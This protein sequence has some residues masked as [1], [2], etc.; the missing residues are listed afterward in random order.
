MGGAYTST[1]RA[2][3][4]ASVGVWITLA[5]VGAACAQGLQ[6]LPPV[7]GSPL[8]APT[9]SPIATGATP[10]MVESP[11]TALPVWEAPGDVSSVTGPAVGSIEAT[12][13]YAEPFGGDA[14]FSS[15]VPF[16]DDVL[17]HDL[18][19]GAGDSRGIERI[20]DFK[21]GF[22]Q[23]VGFTGT[24]IP[25]FDDTDVGFSDL[26]ALASF[27]VPLPTTE[28]PMLITPK[29]MVRYLD[30]PTS[31][32]LPARLYDTSIEFRWLPKLTDRLR[33]A[34]AI[35]P[36]LHTD[37]EKSDAD[38]FRTP[39]HAVAIYDLS[40]TRQFVFGAM[41]LDREDISVLPAGGLILKPNEDWQFDLLFPYPKIASRLWADG[42]TEFWHYVAAEFGSGP[43][44]I[45][46]ADG[47]QDVI[48]LSDYRL[49][50]GLEKKKLGG[51]WSRIEAGYVFG[52]EIEFV[53]ND[54]RY[55]PSP[56][57][58]LRAGVQY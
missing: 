36:G 17:Y 40:P 19:T 41:Y 25:S 9:F 28:W 48:I 47:R 27:G 10:R 13:V 29:F 5:N 8:A 16:G 51:L 53:S 26:E 56:T 54:P 52:R 15:E 7:G 39:G 14:I 11:P 43:Y 50:Y 42:R 31:P 21:S 30:G 20:P 58:L 1:M 2:V 33:L 12:P 34:I 46:R 55:Q 18:I 44:S 23:K 57:F 35:E 4:L 38:A 37:F 32:D 3:L 24:W 49:M 6:R 22:F 45:R